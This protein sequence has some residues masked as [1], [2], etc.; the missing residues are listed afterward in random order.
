MPRKKLAG[1]GAGIRSLKTYEHI[2]K[3]RAVED[4]EGEGK[5]GGE[6]CGGGSGEEKL[7]LILEGE[8]SV[9]GNAVYK[10]VEVDKKY[11]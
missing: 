1:V 7:V 5:V 11:L 8:A 3:I 2:V 6:G 4:E 9:H 10:P